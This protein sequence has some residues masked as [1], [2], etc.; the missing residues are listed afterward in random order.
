VP[1]QDGIARDPIGAIMEQSLTAVAPRSRLEILQVLGL[2]M[3]MEPLTL[4]VIHVDQVVIVL[5][6][7]LSG[8]LMIAI[9]T[10]NVVEEV[11]MA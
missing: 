7:R 2:E 9:I 3:G 11:I 8:Y 1:E 4:Y 6:R 5:A 10:V